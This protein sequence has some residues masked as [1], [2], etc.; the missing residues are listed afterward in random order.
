[1]PS[2][3]TIE[4]CRHLRQNPTPAEELLWQHLRTKQL[5]GLKFRRQHP[6]SGFILDFYCPKL[7][8][9]IELDGAI[10]KDKESREYDLERTRVLAENRIRVIRFWNAEVLDHLE[11]VL[12][13]IQSAVNS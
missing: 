5:D 13:R 6:E 11:S 4:T 3:E 12:A 1:M 10:H 9:A 8:L 2:P 7:R